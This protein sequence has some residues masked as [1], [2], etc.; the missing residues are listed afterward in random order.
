MRPLSTTLLLLVLVLIT[1]LNT[2]AQTCSGSLGDPVINETF[3]AGASPG[4]GPPISQAATN[5]TYVGNQCPNDGTYTIATFSGSC[6]SDLWRTIPS[7]HTGDKN[8]YMMI[9]NA[10]YQPGIFYTQKASGSKLCPNTTYEFA[11][12]IA[13][14][15]YPSTSTQNFIK[16]NITFTI[17]TAD[18]RSLAPPYNT[19]DI[20]PKDPNNPNDPLWKHYGTF[21]TTP[22]DGADIVVTMTNN[23]PGGGGNDLALDDITFRPCG[24]IIQAGFGSANG[25]NNQTLCAGDNATYT[26]SATQSG[27][28]D[29]HYQWQ[30]NI[31]GTGW[32]DM[33]GATGSTLLLDKEFQN[34]VAGN[35]QYRFGVLNGVSKSLDCRIY[36]QPLTVQVNGLPDAGVPPM[37]VACE[38]QPLIL[39]A[40]NGGDSY[41][42]TG[43]NNFLSNA[44]NTTVSGSATLSNE[45]IY[46]L[47]VVVKNC[48]TFTTTTVKVYPKIVATITP[49]VSICAGQSTALAA[50]GGLTYKWTPSTGLDHDDIANPVAAPAQTTTYN[51]TISNN[52]CADNS[53]S[54]TVTV[55]KNPTAN[56]GTGQT[57]FGGQS[58]HLIGTLS[59]DNITDYYWTP[60]LYLDN[61]RSLTPIATPP[62][63]ITYTLNVI[64]GSCGQATSS[65]SIRV[66][67]QISI[68][69]T[70]T[71]NGDG[72]N[73]S[74]NIKNL[75]TYPEGLVLI[76]N[77]DGQQVFKSTGYP[78][79]WDGTSNGSQVPAGTYYY[80]IDLKNGMPTLSG[81]VLVVR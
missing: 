20:P 74:W 67:E 31:N 10:S 72:V 6:F 30:Q 55:S 4:Q 75:V 65:V 35:Y 21:F 44:Q 46:T 1:A 15:I 73:D 68:P 9:V 51:V 60:S 59:G 69:N 45:G 43:P 77:R 71:P 37:T 56:A 36:S 64:S 54:V 50:T 8:G 80:V 28:D 81:W 34:A 3:G 11:A 58:V 26:L 22:S 49:P 39:N 79:P 19:G 5:Y 70:F 29:P 57:I 27:Y 40:N 66:Y 32:V 78:K 76:Y 41:E 17:K 7:D 2:S 42:W 16:P 25:I 52:G 13:N 62:Q 23:A 61:P 38:G 18:G 47:K 14:L 63:D 48:P 53:H 24:P 12:W 33:T